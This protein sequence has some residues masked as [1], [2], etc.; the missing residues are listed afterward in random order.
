[1]KYPNLRHMRVFTEVARLK[2]FA[3]AAQNL[4][5]SQSAV[6]QAIAK[7]EQQLGVVLIARTHRE[8]ALT[9][10]GEDLLAAAQRILEDVERIMR[11]GTEWAGLRRGSLRLLSIPSIA[12]RILPGIVGMFRERHPSIAVEVSD[13][14]DRPLRQRVEAGDGDLAFL[15]CDST[16]QA[17]RTLPLLLDRF[18]VLCPRN[19]PF[20]RRRRIEESRLADVTLI[21]LKR[22]AM[23]RAYI[24][25]VVT[26]LPRN[27]RVIEVDQTSTLIG[28]VEAGLGVALISGLACPSAA[29]ESVVTRPFVSNSEVTRLVGFA[30]PAD[31]L[32]S[33]AAAAFVLM[34]LEFL[35]HEQVALPNGVSLLP[36]SQ[37]DIDAF[38]N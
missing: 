2:S 18:L 28:M 16:E 33:P 36:L 34:T 26:R 37:A 15:T 24:D 3:A 32:P 38:L 5:V 7:L 11:H 29:L 14:K 4:H 22:G 20:A 10:A 13:D 21:M 19:H 23:L 35:N 1:M 17:F 8:V 27:Q 30:R 9:Q 6:S 31:R 25:G 12:H